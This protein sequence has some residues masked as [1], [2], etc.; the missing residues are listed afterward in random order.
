MIENE[1]RKIGFTDAGCTTLEDLEKK[2]LKYYRYVWDNLDESEQIYVL[3]HEYGYYI[4]LI[5]DPKWFDHDILLEE[6]HELLMSLDPSKEDEILRIKHIP[7]K[8]YVHDFDWRD[9]FTDDISMIIHG[10]DIDFIIH[11]V[12]QGISYDVHAFEQAI[13]D[14]AQAKYIFIQKTNL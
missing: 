5:D 9:R 2:S 11:E 1:F 3:S 13:I 6:Y 7:Y 10:D 12:A 8:Y 4:D 14:V